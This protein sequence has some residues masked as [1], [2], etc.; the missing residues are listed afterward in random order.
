M[1]LSKPTFDMVSRKIEKLFPNAE[2]E[3]KT[4][5][6]RNSILNFTKLMTIYDTWKNQMQM[7]YLIL[8]F[9]PPCKYS[10]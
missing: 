1:A 5:Q 9:V 2:E 3:L 8:F 4:L 6:R 7:F 10:L